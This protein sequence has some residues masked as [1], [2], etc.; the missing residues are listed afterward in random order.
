MNKR[1]TTA[2]KIDNRKKEKKGTKDSSTIRNSIIYLD[3]Y[4]EGN[5]KKDNTITL[6]IPT[7]KQKKDNRYKHLNV[8]NTKT[9]KEE[10]RYADDHH[11]RI[12]SLLTSKYAAELRNMGYFEFNYKQRMEE[13][14]FID[15]L[16]EM[17]SRLRKP[18]INPLSIHMVHTNRDQVRTEDH[19]F[20]Q[21]HH[22]ILSPP[23]ST[24]IKRQRVTEEMV[25]DNNR[26]N[27]HKNKESMDVF[28][29]SFKRVGDKYLRLG[30]VTYEE[31]D[32]RWGGEFKRV[33]VNGKVP[34]E[35][36]INRI[37]DD[38][39]LR[40]RYDEYDDIVKYIEDKRIEKQQKY[41][42][43]T[44]RTSNKAEGLESPHRE[45][46]PS[47]NVEGENEKD[48]E[49]NAFGKFKKASK[50][51]ISISKLKKKSNSDNKKVLDKPLKLHEV[52][53]QS[54]LEGS[55]QNKLV[56]S[57]IEDFIMKG[58]YAGRKKLQ[59]ELEAGISSNGNVIDDVNSSKIKKTQDTN[60]INEQYLSDE[61]PQ[62]EGEDAF[63]GANNDIRRSTIDRYEGNK[64][65]GGRTVMN[66]KKV[67]TNPLH[68][69]HSHLLANDK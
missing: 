39:R 41:I 33:E 68:L 3:K 2:R 42:D 47:N 11:R 52:K 1:S 45:K 49:G 61:N 30:D 24:Y 15:Q 64:K 28:N 38:D 25:V 21:N 58:T 8:D 12:N 27:I 48:K 19:V 22:V 63:D 5:N 53:G 31:G 37:A 34:F 17:K 51:I 6:E 35:L 4:M 18:E 20:H 46:S 13:N 7:L 54:G 36:E 44:K 62:L 14:H 66:K 29:K 43:D 26:G 10:N 16:N 40:G 67:Q 65:E 9:K 69:S 57:T 32:P 23:L 59:S 50:G 55:T 60:D 56:K